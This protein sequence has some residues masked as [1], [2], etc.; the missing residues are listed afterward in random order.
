VNTRYFV[1][2]ELLLLIKDFI[3]FVLLETGNWFIW[4]NAY[5]LQLNMYSMAFYNK[6]QFKLKSHN[7]TVLT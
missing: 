5:Y 6:I 7:D 2:E 4:L 3:T 1:G